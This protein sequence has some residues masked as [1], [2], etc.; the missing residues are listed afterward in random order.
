MLKV[1]SFRFA[2][3]ARILGQQK[4]NAQMDE[5]VRIFHEGVSTY[6]TRRDSETREEGKLDKSRVHPDNAA[7]L[8]K[9]EAGFRTISFFCNCIEKKKFKQPIHQP[10]TQKVVN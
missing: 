7:A 2:G 4:V 5:I 9:S 10:Q 3:H 8:I 1:K 6:E